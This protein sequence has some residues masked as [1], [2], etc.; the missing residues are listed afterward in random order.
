MKRY[1]MVGV[2]AVVVVALAA[3][4][5]ASLGTAKP[6]AS[7]DKV[8]LQLKWVPQAQFAGSTRPRRRGTSS[9]SGST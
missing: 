4:M 9:S 5:F 8:T 6:A 2:T 7:M 3:L 1:R